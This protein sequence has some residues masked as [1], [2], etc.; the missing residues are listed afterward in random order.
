ME[1]RYSVTAVTKLQL[2]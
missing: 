1:N 2:L